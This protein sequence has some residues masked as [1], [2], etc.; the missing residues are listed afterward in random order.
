V[1]LLGGHR[2]RDYQEVL[3]LAAR[4]AII[5]LAALEQAVKEMLEV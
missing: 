1:V 2:Q 3:V 4:A 5:M